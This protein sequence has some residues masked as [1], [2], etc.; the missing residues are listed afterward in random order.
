MNRPGVIWLITENAR[1]H[2]VHETITD[3]ERKVLCTV[4]SVTR[5]EYYNALNAGFAPEYVFALAL[6]ADYHDERKLKYQGKIYDIRRV[7]WTD[8]GGVELTA[9]RSDV[10]DGSSDADDGDGND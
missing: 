5:S 1:T 3:T 10:N 2:G 9:E 8:E 6:S 4:K 7:Y